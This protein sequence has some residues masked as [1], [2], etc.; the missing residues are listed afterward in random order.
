M[1]SY[2]LDSSCFKLPE[3][4]TL[5]EVCPRDGFQ[6][7]EQWI[8]TETKI[9]IIEGIFRSGAKNIE[10][11][12]FVSPKAI[13]QMKDAATVAEY[14]VAMAK[15]TDVNIMALIPNVKGAE[16]AL[17][18]GIKKVNYIISAS[19]LHN[20]KNMNRTPQ[21]SFEALCE[22]KKNL[23]EA[24]VTLGV[25]TAFGCP[26][27]GKVPVS[28]VIALMRS[29]QEIGINSFTLCDTIG[30]ANPRQ[31]ELLLHEV[32]QNFSNIQLALH[33]HNTH[34]M[35]LANIYAAMLQGVDRFESA[36]GGL[37][38]CPFAPGAAGNAA[39]EDLVNMLNRMGIN[40]NID[41]AKLLDVAN[42]IRE[43]VPCSISGMLIK[44]RRY[45]EFSF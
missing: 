41:L 15:N 16:R 18:C 37:G 8:P 19:P 31:V 22:L 34:G 35:A 24:E 21:Q 2:P 4:V 45:D 11:T 9:N 43:L 10:V 29:A 27:Q 26:F 7:I 28:D 32:K 20:Q 33:L 42:Q 36:I 1:N 17:S 44:A 3:R 5:T 30:V 12:S 23:P 6:N 25:A 39:T 40:S 14:A 38:G 13:P